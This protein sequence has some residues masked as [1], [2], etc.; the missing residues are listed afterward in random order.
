MLEFS[1]LC[2]CRALLFSLLF[3]VGGCG[4]TDEPAPSA[5]V[6]GNDQAS[7]P[8]PAASPR[9]KPAADA[10]PAVDSETLAYA[11]IGDDLI[12]GHF[13]F[14]SDMIEPL[15]AVILI[16]DIWG[17]T[18]ETRVLADR[19]AAQGYMVLAVDLFRGETTADVVKSRT[20][21]VNALED[22]EATASN[23]RQA[24]NFVDIAGA[25]RKAALGYGM[26]GTWALTAAEQFPSEIDATV[27]YYGEVTADEVRL[28]PIEGPV[29]GLFG[30]QDRV[31]SV[32]AVTDFEAAMRRLGK[33]PTVQI[34][35]DVGHAFADSTK[36]TF[37]ADTT[38]DAWRRTIDFL[39][40][41][42]PADDG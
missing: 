9:R 25:P 32:S 2:R 19:L 15:P 13:A 10:T 8:A 34:Y 33:A 35:S 36:P 23:L 26:G 20:L 7:V 28:E 4:G 39:A 29:L 41:N 16:H 27:I 6:A 30:G 24:L 40:E 11:E 37:D 3:V 42:I 31:V 22:D 1:N 21:T 38:A 14:P 17:L 5:P 18:D 12:Y